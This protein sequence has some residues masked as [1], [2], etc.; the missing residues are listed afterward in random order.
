MVLDTSL[1]NIQPYKT[2]IK[3]KVK[4]SRKRGSTLPYTSVLS[5][6]KRETSIYLF[7]YFKLTKKKKQK[8]PH[9]NNY[10]RR[11]RRLHGASEVPVV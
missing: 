6:F 4:Q 7:I 5:P 3:G 10:W 2:P 11:L 1:L 8:V 9:K